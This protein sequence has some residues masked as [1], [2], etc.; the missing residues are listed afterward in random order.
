LAKNCY[1]FPNTVISVQIF[2]WK[3][4]HWFFE[5]C[6]IIGCRKNILSIFVALLTFYKFIIKKKK[7]KISH[8][9]MPTL[10]SDVTVNSYNNF[11]LFSMKYL[12]RNDSIWKFV[13]IFCQTTS[14]IPSF[15]SNIF[16]HVH[17]KFCILFFLYYKFIKC[18]ECNKNRQYVFS[19]T[20]YF[21]I[22]KES[23]LLFFFTNGYLSLKFENFAV[24][25]KNIPYYYDNKNFIR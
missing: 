24:L 1:K 12:Y 10:N 7:K 5:D 14:L 9:K 2:H 4:V 11:Y 16:N 25:S 17:L 19:T 21:A 20:N 13:T 8:F 22:F 6:K 3:Q 15:S 23:M 18:Q